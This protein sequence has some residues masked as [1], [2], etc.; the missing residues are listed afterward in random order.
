[1]SIHTQ[2]CQL[3]LYLRSSEGKVDGFVG[4]LTSAKWLQKHCVW[5]KHVPS[6]AAPTRFGH[7]V[8]R[9][10][11]GPPVQINVPS[12]SDKPQLTRTKLWTGGAKVYLQSGPNGYAGST[13]FTVESCL[14]DGPYPCWPLDRYTLIPC[15][16]GR[17]KWGGIEMWPSICPVHWE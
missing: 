14:G 10:G 2:I 6:P 5:D 8:I 3:N 7:V 16:A 4:G 13:I 11:G 9:I 1:M 15:N 17:G 12:T